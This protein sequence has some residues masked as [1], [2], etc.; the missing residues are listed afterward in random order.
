MAQH[1]TRGCRGSRRRSGAT[2]QRSGKAACQSAMVVLFLLR[3]D[4]V[5]MQ[6]QRV[7]RSE[8]S[9]GVHHGPY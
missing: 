2:T 9:N 8:P 5:F 1:W 6:L 7:L 3:P 4:I